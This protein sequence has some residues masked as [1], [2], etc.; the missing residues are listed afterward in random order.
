MLAK[1][2][3]VKLNTIFCDFERWKTQKA[4]FSTAASNWR[5]VRIAVIG[6]AKML[7]S[8]ANVR[9][10][11]AAPQRRDRLQMSALGRKQTCQPVQ[12]WEQATKRHSDLMHKSGPLSGPLFN[13]KIK[14]SICN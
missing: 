11:E 4:A 14:I 9:F 12:L 2:L 13:F 10:G 5:F 7:R 3:N 1:N 6:P 8:I